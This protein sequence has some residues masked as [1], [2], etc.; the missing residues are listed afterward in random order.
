[1][2]IYISAQT[3]PAYVPRMVEV[4]GQN[5]QRQNLLQQLLGRHRDNAFYKNNEQKPYTPKGRE[6]HD[7]V[8]LSSGAKIVNIGRGL[9]LAAEIRSAGKSDDIA[10]RVKQ[11]SSD[12]ERIGRLF[13]EV[14]AGFG[15]FFR[16]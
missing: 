5:A 16:R 2:T 7:T 10:A 11:G 12:I 13:R 9:D 15:S 6:I 14:F 8:E 3:N 4:S 1:V